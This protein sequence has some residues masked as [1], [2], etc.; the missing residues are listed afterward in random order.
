[1]DDAHLIC[2]STIR[3]NSR[4]TLWLVPHPTRETRI[5]SSPVRVESSACHLPFD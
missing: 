5:L 2:T 4:T 3:S 1:M